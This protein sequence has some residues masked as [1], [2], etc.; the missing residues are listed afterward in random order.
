MG[1]D[2][3]CKIFRGDNFELVD[4]LSLGSNAD[5]VGYDPATKYLY[6]G[7][8]AFKFQDRSAGYYRYAH[9]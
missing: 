8:G 2:G 1:K 4:S 9:Q 5:H 6:V 7:I 3:T